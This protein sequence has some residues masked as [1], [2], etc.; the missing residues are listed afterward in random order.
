[1][2]KLNKIILV[3]FSAGWLVPMWLAAWLFADFWQGEGWPRLLGQ[4]PGNSFEWFGPIKSCLNLGFAWLAA[5][6]AY[7]SWVGAAA[8]K[9]G[10]AG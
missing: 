9:R 10:Q 3:A 2:R 8:I 7:W 5:A 4:R 6:I 1:M